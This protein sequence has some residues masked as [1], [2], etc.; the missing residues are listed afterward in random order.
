MT[1]DRLAQGRRL[2]E[3]FTC[4]PGSRRAVVAQPQFECVPDPR[5][6]NGVTDESGAIASG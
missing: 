2:I 6:R 4:V 5:L 3:A 1:S